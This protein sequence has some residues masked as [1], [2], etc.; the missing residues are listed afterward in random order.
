MPLRDAGSDMLDVEL[1][2]DGVVVAD[3]G[4]LVQHPAEEAGFGFGNRYWG[5]ILS[6]G[7]CSTSCPAGAVRA[8][9]SWRRIRPVVSSA[10]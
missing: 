8:C 9:R 6:G 10:L 3:A 5:R 1:G 2:H 7:A 4:A